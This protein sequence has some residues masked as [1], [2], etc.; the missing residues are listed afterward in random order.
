[1]TQTILNDT[2]LAVNNDS[3][4]ISH[5]YSNVFI[6]VNTPNNDIFSFVSND[7]LFTVITTLTIS[8]LV[9]IISR[10]IVIFDNRRKEQQTKKY[11]KL[12]ANK[13]Y[14][15]QIPQLTEGYERFYQIIDTDNG[16]PQTTPK[17]PDSDYKRFANSDTKVLLTTFKY[18]TKISK[19]I[20][21]IDYIIKLMDESEKYHEKVLTKTDKMRDRI[22]ELF[23]SYLT[24]LYD[25]LD[26]ERENNPDYLTDRVWIFINDKY[27]KY[28]EDFDGKRSLTAVVNEIIRPIRKELVETKY[29]K[30]KQ[31]GR[32]I[33]ILSKELYLRYSELD[34]ITK[35][36]RIQYKDFYE[37]I[38]QVNEFEDIDL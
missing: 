30:S 15:T 5:D 29:H 26:S 24:K 19:V 37:K 10:L 34:S 31:L 7:T 11:F 18:S 22:K 33:F 14:K 13:I 1:M 25:Y 16:I 28:H 21:G 36:I 20:S 9:I 17:Q 12:L 2:I 6:S 23:E 3:I 35:E 8:I 4:K 38:K 27:L 32:E